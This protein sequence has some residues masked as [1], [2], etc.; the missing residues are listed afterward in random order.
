[1]GDVFNLQRQS[2]IALRIRLHK[3]V[4]SEEI[5]VRALGNSSGDEVSCL[6]FD[7]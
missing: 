5:I 1:M 3:V 4:E 7:V 6:R 2:H